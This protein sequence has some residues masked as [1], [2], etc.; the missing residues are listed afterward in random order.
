MNLQKFH[1]NEAIRI[2]KDK[3]M[4]QF[5]KEEILNA[6]M[7]VHSLDKPTEQIASICETVFEL[8][9]AH[10]ADMPEHL[11]KTFW[12]LQQNFMV[13]LAL[14]VSRETQQDITSADQEDMDNHID[15]LTGLDQPDIKRDQ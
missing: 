12:H 15:P 2:N 6:F 14:L 9:D 5:S 7:S 1:T 11:I 4:E 3:P 8:I 13:N 10:E